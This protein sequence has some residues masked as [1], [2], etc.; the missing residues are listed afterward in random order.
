MDD[1]EIEDREAQFQNRNE[2]IRHVIDVLAQYDESELDE[3]GKKSEVAREH[4][5]EQHR[6][7]YV[8]NHWEELVSY[9][10][11]ANSDPLD[12]NAVKAA[13]DDDVLGEMAASEPVADGAG[14]IQI[15]ITLTLDEV[16]RA[17]KLL[18]GDLGLKVYGQTLE[19]DFDR[20]VVR[21]ILEDR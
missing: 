11:F 12:P 17:I 21:R 9:R 18:P 20:G 3:H 8:L 16:F 7:Y 15:D 14:D 1:D 5:I 13:Y 6:I 2:A 10:R 4:G 19:S